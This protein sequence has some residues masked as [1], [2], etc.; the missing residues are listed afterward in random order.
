[1]EQEESWY[2]DQDQYQEVLQAEVA[3]RY[4]QDRMLMEVV[5]ET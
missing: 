5:Q 4:I 2:Y 3:Y 1:M